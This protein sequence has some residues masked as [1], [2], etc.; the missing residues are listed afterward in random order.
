MVKLD[1]FQGDAMN[2]YEHAWYPS[3]I[4]LPEATSGK[5]HVRHRTVAP[6]EKVVVVGT[7]QALLRGITPIVGVVE[8]PLRVHE[9]V[10]D[11]YG[12][13]MTDL[14][15]ELNQIA[16]LMHDVDPSGSVLVSGLGLGIVAKT[17]AMRRGV[18]DVLVVERD[19]HV[20]KLCARKDYRVAVTDIGKYLLTT[21]ERFDYYLLDTW[22]ETGER[23]WWSQVMPLRRLIRQRCGA[24]PVVH[25]WA[26]DIMLGQIIRTL[27]TG[28]PHW[29]YA[30]LPMPMDEAEADRFVRDVG[31]PSWEAR[32]GAIVDA[33][34]SLRVAE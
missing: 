16:E 10:H 18:T 27:T 26:E 23:T 21:R 25:C 17:L 13:W 11:D 33:S 4:A 6:G 9:L 24:E 19:R 15:E 12:V 31:L 32:Y 22:Q 8:K 2:S 30:G 28:I 34:M 3:P 20:V 29:H 7:R 1:T 5:A 14:P